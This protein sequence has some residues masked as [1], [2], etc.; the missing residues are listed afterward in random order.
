M[1]LFDVC[2][3]M[4]LSVSVCVACIRVPKGEYR[5]AVCVHL[6]MH[7]NNSFVVG[8]RFTWLQAQELRERA[9]KENKE[10]KKRST[11]LL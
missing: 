6:C 7:C 11:G 8:Y 1:L 3:Y 9:K 5:R 4:C 10:K 2:V